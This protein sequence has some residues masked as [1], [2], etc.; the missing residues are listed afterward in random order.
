MHTI[1]RRSSENYTE[2]E[3]QI[4]TDLKFEGGFFCYVSTTIEDCNASF[5]GVSKW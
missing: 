4:W 5:Q 3:S 2:T 1:K